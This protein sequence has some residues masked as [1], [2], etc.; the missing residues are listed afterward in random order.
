MTPQQEAAALGNFVPAYDRLGQV[1]SFGDVDRMSGF[2]ES[3][4]GLDDL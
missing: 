3:G 1:R 4:Y 2:P